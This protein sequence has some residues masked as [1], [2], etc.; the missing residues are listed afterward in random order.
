MAAEA[1][2]RLALTSRT[3]EG[4]PAASAQR[5]AQQTTAAELGV[6]RYQEARWDQAHTDGGGELRELL[7]VQ[8]VDVDGTYVLAAR[9]RPRFAGEADHLEV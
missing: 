3:W 2:G 6:V 4:I 5:A 1:E 7:R 8:E 9:P